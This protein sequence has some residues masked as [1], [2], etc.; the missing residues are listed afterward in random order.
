MEDINYDIDVTQAAF[1]YL[2]VHPNN[3]YEQINHEISR[4]NKKYCDLDFRNVFMGR[5]NVD[6][7]NN[8]IKK[9]VY[10][11]SCYK[12]IIPDQKFEHLYLVMD[13]IYE[14]YAKHFKIY[15]Q[16]E[17]DM[18][19]DLVIKSCAQ[20]AVENITHRYKSLQTRMSVP[21]PLPDPVNCSTKG[22]K[23]ETPVI[24]EK[25]HSEGFNVNKRIK[26]K[27]V[28]SRSIM[29]DD[30]GINKYCGSF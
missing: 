7:I 18:L 28:Y 14:K 27:D 17:L 16:R 25:L 13:G 30:E 23:S 2:N 20:V 15:K 6:W 22:T 3:Y 24:S 9:E 5:E 19:N 1:L 11:N 8:Q 12:Y 10:E 26:D 29:V 4:P 21:K